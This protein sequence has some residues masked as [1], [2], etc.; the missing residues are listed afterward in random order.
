VAYIRALQLSQHAQESDAAQGAQFDTLENI[1]SREGLP[2]DTGKQWKLPPTAVYGTPNNQDNGIPQ[3]ANPNDKNAIGQPA[4][5]AMERQTTPA[6]PN[7][8]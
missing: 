6:G 8:Q 2:A 5:R 7:K 1:A 4:P 3:L